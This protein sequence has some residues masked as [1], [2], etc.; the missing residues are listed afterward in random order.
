MNQV[1]EGYKE[2][3]TGA[4]RPVST[5]K[6]IDLMRD[7]LTL[8]IVEKAKAT[9]DHL[10]K[11]KAE[12][13]GD[14]EA[15]VELSAEQYGVKLG[16]IK[17]NVTLTSFDGRY[18]IIRSNADA[19]VFDERIHAAKVLIDECLL[20]WAGTSNQY[21]VAIVNDIF[22]T[23]ADGELRTAAILS[24]RRHDIPDERWMQ[25]MN[26]I[27]DALNRVFSKAYVRVY[28]RIGKT[29]SYKQIPLDIAGV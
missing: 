4:L 26:I 15:F 18:R 22:R 8:D 7:K 6:P 20:D 12:V 23:N 24:L 9:R 1:P 11:L 10:I 27:A 21:M 25:A 13:F 5:I 28:E 16:G 3:G 29:D 14:I 2:D 19:I 17:G